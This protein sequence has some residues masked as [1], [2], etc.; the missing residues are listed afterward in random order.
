M[1]DPNLIR[2]LEELSMNAFPAIISL[3]D[4]GWVLQLSNDYARRVKAVYPLYPGS[5]P[6]QAKID[7]CEAMYR[8]E[9]HRVVFKLTEASQPAHL[10]ETLAAQGYGKDAN[11]AV[12]LLD[13]GAWSGTADGDVTLSET[14]SPQWLAAF[15]RMRGLSDADC[16]S[17]GQIIRRILPARRY[18]SITQNGQIVA[19][20]SAVLQNDFIGFY[21][22]TTDPTVRRQ[23]H[24]LR[25]MQTLLAWA[26]AEGAAYGYL[27]VMTQNTPALALYAKLGFHEAYRYWY[28]MKN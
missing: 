3:H 27:Q 10:D 5:K 24:S 19:C 25:L 15:G 16:A 13:L 7:A 20:G 17:H 22:V 18:A 21:D 8:S 6:L 28:R 1:T 26:K 14:P 4:D 12:H 9:G 2:H 23:G 11:T